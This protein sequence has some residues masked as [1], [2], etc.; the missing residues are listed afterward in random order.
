MESGAFKFEWATAKAA[1]NVAKHGVA[2][3]E[4][5]TVF[6]DLLAGA[7]LD[8]E[9]SLEEERLLTI[10]LSRKG[11]ILLVSHTERGRVVRIISAREA[12]RAERE[13]YERG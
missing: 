5:A 8:R 2:F 11:R 10:G 13:K 3:E 6:D 9:H 4:A 7:S 1:I 12:T